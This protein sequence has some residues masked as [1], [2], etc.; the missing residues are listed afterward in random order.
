VAVEAD[1]SDEHPNSL[2]H[3][4]LQTGEIE[5]KGRE[6]KVER[7]LLLLRIAESYHLC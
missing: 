6:V 2:S 4:Y 1:L 7:P 5:S 3:A